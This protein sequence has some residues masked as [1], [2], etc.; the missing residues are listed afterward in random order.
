MIWM[1]FWLWFYWTLKILKVR[2]WSMS[3]YGPVIISQIPECCS[4]LVEESLS[5]K[6]SDLL[7]RS[8]RLD[9]YLGDLPFLCIHHCFYLS[10]VQLCWGHFIFASLVLPLFVFRS[11]LG[12][13]V[14]HQGLG[15]FDGITW[16]W[17]F[18]EMFDF[19]AVEVIFVLEPLIFTMD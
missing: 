15:P 3:Y 2:N 4:I 10:Y 5:C 13:N 12:L 14:L 17:P 9:H 19:C 6:T 1:H 18:L 7:L 8:W 16:F 11:Y